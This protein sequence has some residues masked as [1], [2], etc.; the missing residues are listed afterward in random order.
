LICLVWLGAAIIFMFT[1]SEI[2]GSALLVATTAS[3]ALSFGGASGG[4]YV[5]SVRIEP[6]FVGSMLHVTEVSR[7]YTPNQR[8]PTQSSIDSSDNCKRFR[9]EG[10]SILRASTALYETQQGISQEFSK[11]TSLRLELGL[12]FKAGHAWHAN[13]RD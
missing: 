11:A 5:P 3:R 9:F 13:V 4:V 8:S 2:R 6:I 7:K 1:R 10:G 12:Q